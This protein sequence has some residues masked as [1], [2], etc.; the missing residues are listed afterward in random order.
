MNL[1]M[2][3]GFGVAVTAHQL[4]AGLS[5]LGHNVTLCSTNESSDFEPICYNWFK[6]PV[7]GANRNRLLPVFQR[8]V[9]TTLKHLF[10]KSILPKFDVVLTCSF[11]FYGSG[12]ILKTPEVHFDF[13]QA[14]T[15]K[16]S[17]I[18]SA[19]YQYLRFSEQ[20]M[21]SRAQ[22]VFTISNFLTTRLHKSVIDPVVIHLGANQLL[23]QNLFSNHDIG[24][25]S[26]FTYGLYVGR[27]DPKPQPYKNVL[28]LSEMCTEI[29]RT[30]PNFKLICAGYG[31]ESTVE[32]FRSRGHIVYESAS[33]SLLARLYQSCSLYLTATLWEGLDLPILEASWFGKPSIA[34]NVGAHPELP[35]AGLANDNTEWTEYVRCLLDNPSK[36]QKYGAVARQQAAEL[37]YNWVACVNQVESELLKFS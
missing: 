27:L 19:N 30:H 2:Q 12:R 33:D 7:Y 1:R 16:M 10:Q 8:E 11:P 37:G 22:K 13:G 23:Q 29:S 18:S 5:K 20:T 26:E 34:F 15:T 25:N 31:S 24:L 21:Q 3:K 36:R 14:P 35:V 9:S 28:R 6:F 17:L 32:H 4:A